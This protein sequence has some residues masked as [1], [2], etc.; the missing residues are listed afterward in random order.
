MTELNAFFGGGNT[1][2]GFVNHL[3][4]ITKGTERLYI[5]KGGC[6]C[7]KSTL[8]KKIAE[9]AENRGLLV[10]RIFCASDPESLDGVIVPE[11]GVGI[12]DGT[13]PHDLSPRFTGAVDNLVDLG[14]YWNNAVLKSQ[15][16]EI[17]DLSLAKQGCYKEA[18]ALLAAAETLRKAR[19]RITEKALIKE[20][21]FSAAERYGERLKS[22]RGVFSAELCPLSA[23]CGEGTVTKSVE[24]AEVWSI[25]DGFDIG[26]IFLGALFD[27]L[28]KGGGTLCLSP[29][30]TDPDGLSALYCADGGVLISRHAEEGEYTVNMERFVDKAV[31]RE[32]RTQFKFLR[33]T[34]TELKEK[35]ALYLKKAR[36]HHKRLEEIYSPAVDFSRVNARTRRLVR[37]IFA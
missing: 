30:A 32:N 29:D 16:G 4:N 33:Q 23:F 17:K 25:K 31:L 1:A 9:E 3:E 37:E 24:G 19:R 13:A 7:G 12:A 10:K 36:E 2:K 26:V 15:K 18:Y 34:E 8:M 14:E 20:K 27:T 21:L 11:T 35:A 22:K 6:G 5:L 28:K